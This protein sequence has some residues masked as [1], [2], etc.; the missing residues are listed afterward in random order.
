MYN[1]DSLLFS[2]DRYRTDCLKKREGIWWHP[3]WSSL[4]SDTK[5]TDETDSK[6]VSTDWLIRWYVAIQ[7]KIGLPK[8]LNQP[9]IWCIGVNDQPVF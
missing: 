5:W 9:I 3:R 7:T 2:A 8:S 4:E 1:I 6:S